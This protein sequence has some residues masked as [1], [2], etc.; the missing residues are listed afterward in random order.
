MR[1][2]SGQEAKIMLSYTIP[3]SL[4]TL[5]AA[6]A[7]CNGKSPY[8]LFQACDV[9]FGNLDAVKTRLTLKIT[10]VIIST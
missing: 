3:V 9:K 4:I 6:R 1:V 7:F 10:V 8:R 5:P 2:T